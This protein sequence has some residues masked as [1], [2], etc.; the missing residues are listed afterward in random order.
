MAHAHIAVEML[1]LILVLGLEAK[2]D[3]SRTWRSGGREGWIIDLPHHFIVPLLD[4]SQLSHPN[5]VAPT[6]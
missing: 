2:E 3:G 1:A 5:I 6:H 4:I